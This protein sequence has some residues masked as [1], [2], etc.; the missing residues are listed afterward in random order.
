[1]ANCKCEETT[2]NGLFHLLD[3]RE[4]PASTTGIDFKP[5]NANQIRIPADCRRVPVAS[6]D[7]DA[8]FAKEFDV[9]VDRG[10]EEHL[11]ADQMARL[12]QGS[13]FKLEIPGPSD[14]VP[15]DSIWAVCEHPESLGTEATSRKI[16]ERFESLFPV[17][18]RT[19]DEIE[20]VLG[21]ENAMAYVWV[22][23]FLNAS[24]GKSG[25]FSSWIVTLTFD[26][27][28][29]CLGITDKVDL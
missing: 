11:H 2:E 13:K 7:V 17:Q 9:I 20:S 21:V 12:L 19:F 15:V 8:W 23:G 3:C 16:S 18:G 10:S 29:V 5:L 26:K 27:Y 24:W 1:L 22:D 6:F 4:N 25:L 28:R 14:W